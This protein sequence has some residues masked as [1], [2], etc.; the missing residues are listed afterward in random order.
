MT[1]SL[2]LPRRVRMLCSPSTQRS[3]SATL[4]LPEP[5]GPTM[6]VMPGLNSSTVRG[7]KLLKPC[8]SIRLRYTGCCSLPPKGADEETPPEAEYHH[9]GARARGDAAG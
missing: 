4:D 2:F 8:S 3:P 5:F 7:A 1:S 6:A 9:A